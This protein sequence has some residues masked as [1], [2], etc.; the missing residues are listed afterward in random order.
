MHNMLMRIWYRHFEN[1]W[2]Y[3]LSKPSAIYE[4]LLFVLSRKKINKVAN[5]SS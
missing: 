4:L 5:P 1:K 3:I 2:K